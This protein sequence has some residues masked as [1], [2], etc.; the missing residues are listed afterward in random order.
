MFRAI[1]GIGPALAAVGLVILAA[2]GAVVADEAQR[3]AI[4]QRTAELRELPPLAEIDDEIIS[5]DELNR[6]L[7]GLI[8]E[9]YSREEAAADSRGL[10][11]LGLLPEGADLWDLSL[12]LLGDQVAGYWD[13][14]T[15]QMVVVSTSETASDDETLGPLEE[16]TYAHEV[17]HALQDAH[18]GLDRMMDDGLD[19][20]ADAATAQIALIEGDA[21]IASYDYLAAAPELAAGIAM[22]PM[23]VG[24]DT[25]DV[26]PAA[27]AVSLVF[28]YLSGAEFVTALRDE[29]GW[30]AV[31]AAYADPPVS[32]EQV[33]HPEKYFERDAPTPVA[34]PDL[35]PALGEGWSLVDE[36]VAGELSVALLLADL[37]PGEGF[38]PFTGE[39]RLPVAARNAAEGWDGDRYA[40]WANG[41][42]E[43]L[44]WS[45]VWD[46]EEDATAFARALRAQTERRFSGLYEGEAGND[47]AMQTAEQAARILQSGPEV[48]YVL[49]PDLPTA[50]AAMGALR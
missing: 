29:G 44:V 36:D 23:A 39:I 19:I 13:Q 31:D 16:F 49:A 1:V 26:V 34:L 2:P 9:D 15:D 35:A 40:L 17:V 3:D 24:G 30:A 8:A 5:R 10:I 12:S 45:S 33:M 14:K 47:V 7:P 48:L 18:L 25:L 43:V 46:R 32:T 27:L 21:T 20:D 37:Q 11:A 22:A 28:P 42:T 6:R 41:D 50:D 4:A 38:N